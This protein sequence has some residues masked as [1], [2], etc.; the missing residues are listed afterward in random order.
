MPRMKRVTVSG[1]VLEQEIFNVAPNTKNLRGAAPKPAAERTEQEKAEYNR[2]QS[3]K[4]CI[5]TINATFEPFGSKAFYTTHTFDDAH[6][7]KDYSGVRRVR[8]NYIKRLQYEFPDAVIVAFMGRG[9]RT[10]RFHLHCIIAGVDEKTIREKWKHG[11][12]MRIEPLR[13]HNYYNGIDHG[14]DYTALATYLHGHWKEEQGK[15]KRWRQTKN[16]KQVER[17]RPTMPKRR[18]SLDKPPI[19]P[20]GY[21]L[22]EKR[23][24]NHYLGGY[25]CFKYV[26][27][28]PPDEKGNVKAGGIPRYG[29]VL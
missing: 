21:M 12:V 15:G 25:L 14:R 26:K 27:I 5:R 6:L 19:T 10:K 3:L 23:E 4:R 17:K 11:K 7:P 13:E 24:S 20:K 9:R 29:L 16:V 22:V 2:K 8:D 28:P 1:A 18:Y